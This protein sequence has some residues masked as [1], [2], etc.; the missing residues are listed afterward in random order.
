MT[1]L[2]LNQDGTVRAP[3]PGEHG[4]LDMARATLGPDC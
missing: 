3:A 4:H 1:K 2:Y